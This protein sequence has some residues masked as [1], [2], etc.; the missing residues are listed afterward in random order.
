MLVSVFE[1]ATFDTD[2]LQ[3][4]MPLKARARSLANY[5]ARRDRRLAFD[6]L[7]GSNLSKDELQAQVDSNSV[8]VEVIERAAAPA[9]SAS[10]S[11]SDTGADA[12][13]AGGAEAKSA[14]KAGISPNL[15][16]H[17][18]HRALLPKL[19]ELIFVAWIT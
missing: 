8:T 3:L 9:T 13:S 2:L 14:D 19:S 12:R 7:V 1:L 4:M 5:R 16:K 10:T 17:P 18:K 15:Q 6:I 11:T